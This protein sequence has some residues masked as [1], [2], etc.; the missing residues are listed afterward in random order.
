MSLYKNRYRI[1][2]ARLKNWDYSS[3]GY[4]FITICTKNREH[5]F[6]KKIEYEIQLSDIGKIVFNEWNESFV[7]RS[8]LY[9]DCFVV[10]PDHIHGVVR[11][12]NFSVETHAVLSL[13][14]NGRTPK[15]IS[16]FVAGFKSHAT[17][18]I[19]EYCNT[20]GGSV[21]Q[22]RFHDHVIRDKG[23]L[24]RIRKYIKN[25]PLKW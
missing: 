5:F 13:Q 16:S 10:M 12:N 18:K 19:N 9:C 2:S 3:N 6:G 8:E 4:Y 17:K 21:W 24:N 7:I 22:P 14:G 23:E 1:E 25:N 20:S 15:S 11:I